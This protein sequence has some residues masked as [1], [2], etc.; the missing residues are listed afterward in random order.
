MLSLPFSHACLSTGGYKVHPQAPPP[1]GT[2]QG[3]PVPSILKSRPVG[4]ELSMTLEYRLQFFS[5]EQIKH[6]DE[7]YT[8]D[9]PW[10]RLDWKVS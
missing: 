5:N 7:V 8:G 6:T 3:T 4:M 10:T 1:E 2:L 9:H